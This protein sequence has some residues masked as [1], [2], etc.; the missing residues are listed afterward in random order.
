MMIAPTGRGKGVGFVIPNLLEFPGSVVVLDLKSEDFR[1]TP[2]FRQRHT[3]K[4]WDFS[5]FDDDHGS[6]CFK[7]W[8]PAGKR[9]PRLTSY[10]TA[11]TAFPTISPDSSAR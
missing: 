3:Q 1:F 4:I 2:I 7:R 5:S 10:R 11:S 8:Q 6:H 9:A